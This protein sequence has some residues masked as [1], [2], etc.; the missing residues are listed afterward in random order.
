MYIHQ[1]T[2]HSLVETVLYYGV[3]YE[4]EFIHAVN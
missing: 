4:Y 1:H 3:Y 2:E